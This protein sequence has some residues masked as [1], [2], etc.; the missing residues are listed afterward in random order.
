MPTPDSSDSCAHAFADHHIHGLAGVDFAT[1][2]TAEVRSALALL[3]SRRTT[4]VT[5]SIP[6]VQR[7]HVQAMLDRL[8]PVFDDGLLTGVHFE[9][10][11]IAPEFAGA[12]PHQ[13]ILSPTEPAGQEFLGTLLAQ[14]RAKPLVTMM[15]VAPELEGFATLV[16][17]LV[18]HGIDPA[19]GHTNAT[20]E[21]MRDGI[22]VVYQL[23]GRPV[24]ITH[25]YNAM[26]GFHHREPG[27]LLAVFEAVEHKTVKVELIADRYHV[28]PSV[29]SWWFEKYP[30]SIRLVSDA[31]AATLPSGCK[32]LSV[33]LP[34][35][36]MAPLQY[37]K[38]AG[39]MLA[40]GCTMASG[41]SD[42]LAVHD[43]LVAGG[44][45]HETVCAAMRA[46]HT[47]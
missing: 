35:L 43:A 9:G 29:I 37:P 12:H 1:S 6:T 28:H 45:D 40:D 8:A 3:K 41:A 2:S 17:R 18:S 16:E 32:P 24:T 25:L 46:R 10:P 14:H 39:P 38:T 7:G 33:A 44:L 26:R 13:A 22:E 34:M 30:E 31:S 23:T 20:Y 27:P 42:L 5:A 36:G 4:E 19:L 15:T 47:A 21:Q 11:F